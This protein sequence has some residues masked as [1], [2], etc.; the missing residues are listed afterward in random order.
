MPR[1]PS[2]WLSPPRIRRWQPGGAAA[3]FAPIN[4]V[5][6]VV[7]GTPQVGQVLTTTDGT[8]IG[9]VSF[10]YQWKSNGV[11]VGTNTNTYT[12][13]VGDIGNLITCVVTAT[14]G[15]GSTPA[16][17]NAVGPVT[18]AGLSGQWMMLGVT[19]P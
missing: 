19:Y 12:P 1:D 10:A 6:P 4:T 18:G 11:N 2:G 13:V 3:G 16:T 7:S 14:N 8:W 15:N 5:A 9:A 17:S